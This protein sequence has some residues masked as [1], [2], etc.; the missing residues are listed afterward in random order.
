MAYLLLHPEDLEGLVD[1][2]DAI[3]AIEQAYGEAAT[4]PIVNAPRQRIHSPS[5]VRF[6]TFPGGIPALNVIGV[7]E[8]A[9]RVIQDGARQLFADRE[10]QISLLHDSEN[11]K[12]L[13]IL[14]GA[15]SE[16]TLGYTTQTALRT[17]ATSGVGFKHLARP[18]SKVCALFGAGNQ[19]VTQ[20]FALKNVR[21]IQEVRLCTRTRESAERFAKT[22]GPLF[23]LEI[24]PTEDPQE[25]VSGADVVIAATNTN[26]PVVNGAWLEP[27]QHIAS[28]VGSNIALVK[29]GWLDAPRR[30]LDDE[31][32]ARADR[33]A[34]NSKQ[35]IVKDEQGDLFQPIEAGIVAIEDIAESG[36]VVNG[37]RPS[38]ESDDQI[39]LHKNNAGL[40]VADIAVS[41][42][43]YERA[44]AEGRGRW[45]DLCAAEGEAD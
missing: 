30:E 24:R 34:V 20:L 15:I 23:N 19:A 33:I 38:R 44:K 12:L 22:Y 3:D 36:E 2:A 17:G 6:N 13:A 41:R 1:M 11:S 39:T 31:V 35:Q 14:I 9:E 26:V 42:V 37:S 45:I 40:G 4:W 10:H 18:D 7:V 21:P 29:S 25:A 5:G 28:I 32:I 43:A 27:G 8:H 16:R